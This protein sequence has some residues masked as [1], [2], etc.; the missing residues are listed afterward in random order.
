MITAR[1]RSPVGQGADLLGGGVV[2]KVSETK[3]A[4][5]SSA[6]CP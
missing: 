2:C 6:P 1:N 4:G 3:A 5:S